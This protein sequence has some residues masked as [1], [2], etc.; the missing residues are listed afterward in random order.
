M[1]MF[2]SR[3]LDLSNVDANDRGSFEPI[4]E[5]DY[6][7]VCT[8]F[9]IQKK[10]NGDEG[11]KVKFDVV[12]GEYAGR[13]VFDYINVFHS[14]AMAQEIGQKYLRGFMDAVGIPPNEFESPE[15]LIGYPFNAHVKIEPGSVNKVTGK[16][17]KPSNK[18]SYFHAAEAAEAAPAP[19]AAPV[20]RAAAPASPAPKA[21]AA[22]APAAPAAKMPWK[23]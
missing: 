15:Q 22:A 8:D 17:Y 21:A 5:G 18:I 14:S 13:K 7:L 2:F 9:D 16:T 1:N 3:P 20:K 6:K 4:P 19:K 11:A 23:K 10:E 12:E